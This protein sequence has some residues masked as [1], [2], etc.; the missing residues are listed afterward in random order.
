MSPGEASAGLLIARLVSRLVRR[1]VGWSVCRCIDRVPKSAAQPPRAWVRSDCSSFGGT[2]TRD[3]FPTFTHC[4]RHSDHF[5]QR[6]PDAAR[7]TARRSWRSGEGKQTSSSEAPTTRRTCSSHGRRCGAGS[8]F[9][10]SSALACHRH[11]RHH[12]R[13]QRAVCRHRARLRRA[14]ER[15]RRRC[16]QRTIRRHRT[17]L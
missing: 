13:R 5:R 8:G 7:E 2:Q 9:P 17:F 12:G 3:D 11:G 6:K 1:S 15:R 16:L 14:A 4:W 10:S